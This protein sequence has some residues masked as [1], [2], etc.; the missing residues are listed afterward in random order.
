LRTA[1]KE[2]GDHEQISCNDLRFLARG[3]K[4]DIVPQM[5]LLCLVKQRRAALLLV[6]DS[7]REEGVSGSRFAQSLRHN[8]YRRHLQ[9]DPGS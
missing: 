8:G 9:D 3:N 5:L 1:P 2:L 4:A 7:R 6:Y